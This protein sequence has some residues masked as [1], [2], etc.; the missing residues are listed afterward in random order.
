[1]K[2][3]GSGNTPNPRKVKI[4][5][6]EKAI[7]Y[8]MVE[9]DLM[10]GEHKT[11][12]FLQKNPLGRVPV[13]ETD[14]GEFLTEAI[15]ICRYLEALYPEPNLFGKNANDV[16]QIEMHHSQI[17][18]DLWFQVRSSWKNGPVLEKMGYKVAPE[19]KVFSDASVYAYYEKLNNE[20]S[21]KEYLAASRFT[22]ADIILLVC[23][24]FAIHYCGLK[25]DE[26]LQNLW[27]W[28]GF[29]TSRESVGAIS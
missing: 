8:E 22:I 15:A 26:S 24:D 25:P 11:P 12:E 19:A 23:V 20:L 5:L 21:D 1:M 6:A 14:E 2:L 3:Y 29:I 7:N 27:R 18:A 16:G 13:L 10:N 9:L 17:E 28:H 4:V